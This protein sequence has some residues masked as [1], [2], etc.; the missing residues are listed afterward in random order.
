[1]VQTEL[2]DRIEGFKGDVF[3]VHNTYFEILLEHGVVG[4]AMFAWLIAGLVGIGRRT[5]RIDGAEE[6]GFLE[7]RAGRRLWL[8]LLS[9]YFINATFV[10]M[11]YQFVNGLLFTVAGIL[12]MRQQRGEATAMCEV[13][14]KNAGRRFGGD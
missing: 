2:A 14:L 10:V 13:E 4:C 11:N 3:V 1:V 5:A 7:G 9:V 6:G 12:A 8:L